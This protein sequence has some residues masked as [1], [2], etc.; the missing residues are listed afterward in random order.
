MNALEELA[1]QHKI[2]Q[3]EEEITELQE[4]NS[5]LLKF[6]KSNEWKQR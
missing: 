2:R 1:Y 5:K 6:I 4:Q 3:L